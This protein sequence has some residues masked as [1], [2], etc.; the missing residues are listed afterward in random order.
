VPTTEPVPVPPSFIYG[1]TLANVFAEREPFL[2]FIN[3]QPVA[4]PD[5]EKRP[6]HIFVA[7]PYSLYPEADYRKVFKN[8][9]EA[10]RV[11]FLF[12]D[13]KITDLHILKKIENY[14][15]ESEF[16][17]YDISGWNANVT[18]ELGL[19]FGLGERAFIAFD[20]KKTP[21]AEVP[22]DLRGIDRIEYSSYS[23]L[24]EKVGELIGQELPLPLEHG[25]ESV[26]PLGALRRLAVETLNRNPGLKMGD[27]ATELGINVDLA[28]VVIRPL[29]GSLVRTE[30][31]KRGTKYFLM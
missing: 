20:P 27:I 24:E 21:I 2:P 5:R 14:I 22:A 19:A 25:T 16:G 29:V 31:Q 10:F 30:G 4:L 9:A 18:L 6:R 8:V 13:E 12:A 7:Y 17:I 23:E 28:Q 15:R 3:W 1:S 11:T 26:S